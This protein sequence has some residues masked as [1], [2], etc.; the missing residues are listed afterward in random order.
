[1]TAHADAAEHHGPPAP[2]GVAELLAAVAGSARV[3]DSG[4]GSGRLTVALALAGAEV[5]GLDTNA[6]QLREA[7][8]RAVDAGVDLDLVQADMNDPLPFA[9]G[10]FDAV[11]SRLSLM[12]AADP[13]ATLREFARVLEPDGRVATVLWASLSENPWFAAPREAVG[14][15]LGAE[16]ASFARVFGR[17]G[18]TDEAGGVHRAAGLHDVE[19][20]LLREVVTRAHA[21]EHWSLLARENGHFRR[22]DEAI[23]G[24][25][26][27]AIVAEVD[28]RLSSY[29]DGESLRIPR[30]LVFVTARRV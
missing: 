26:R 3:L 20:R 23:D 11:T 21:A 8:G 25:E 7:R 15:V 17:L 22:V 1:M 14:A 19:A 6:E 30:T 27:A 12:V 13:V 10:S 18:T 16:R 24:D 5:T 9:D 28:R 29:R 4:C 2:F